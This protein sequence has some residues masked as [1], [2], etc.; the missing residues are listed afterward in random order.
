VVTDGNNHK[1]LRWID[2]PTITELKCD[3]VVLS[4]S[5]IKDSRRNHEAL[6]ISPSSQKWQEAAGTPQEVLR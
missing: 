1:L 3:F 2:Y 4:M 5:W 6:S